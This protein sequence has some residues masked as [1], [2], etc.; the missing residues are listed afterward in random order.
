MPP[1]IYIACPEC[2]LLHRREPL[3]PNGMATCRRC[4][5]VLYRNGR[6]GLDRTL[7]LTIAGTILFAIANLY[8]FLT[9]NLEGQ[10]Q[11][12]TLISGII[13]LY[14]QGMP[15][16]ATL[17]LATGIV[18]PLVELLGLTYSLLPLK[19]NRTPW[20]IAPIFRLVFMLKPWAMTEVFLLGILVSIV[21]LSDMARIVPGTALYA[22]VALVFIIAAAAASLDPDTVW[23]RLPIKQ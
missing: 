20:A 14:H 10:V 4:G 16:L 3:P 12:T 23:Q 17:V 11:E 13:A 21:K 5:T 15:L 9:L 22:F 7:A 1:D 2:D 8:P 18:F 19:F 6:N